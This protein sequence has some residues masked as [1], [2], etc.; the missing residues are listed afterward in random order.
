MTAP[1]SHYRWLLVRSLL[2]S[3]ASTA[4]LLTVYYLAPLNHTR[5]SAAL[6]LLGLGL[7]LFTALIILQVRAISGAQHPRLRAVEALSVAV[8]LLL[9]VFAGVYLLMER[10]HPGSFSES[11]NHTDA[12]Y[13]TVTVFATVGFGDITPVT[14]AARV[15]T[16]VQMLVDLAA[17]GVIAKVIFGAVQ[18]GLRHRPD[19][20][21]GPTT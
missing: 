12:L 15:V 20:D 10:A 1:R 16:T 9:I 11:L 3:A 21:Q 8:P 6:A 18:T 4:T 7:V 2:R 17:V 14:G 19:P 5:D 13:F